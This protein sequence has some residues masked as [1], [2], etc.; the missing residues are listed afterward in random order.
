LEQIKEVRLLA[1]IKE[2]SHCKFLEQIKE[3]R[4][5][6]QIKELSHPLLEQIKEV[7]L[8]AQIKEVKL[9]AQIKDVRHCKLLEQTKEL[10][11]FMVQ[12]L[13]HRFQHRKAR[14]LLNSVRRSTPI[15][16]SCV[17]V[18][19]KFARRQ[20]RESCPKT[21]R[22]RCTNGSATS[23]TA[24]HANCGVRLEAGLQRTGKASQRI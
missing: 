11:H 23:V 24:R 20:R 7:R 3:V 18:A 17:K 12:D 6:A 21:R 8:L 10:R 19:G 2:L 9:L 1:Q 15:R 14:A 4:L 22:R 13:L 5:L 16:S